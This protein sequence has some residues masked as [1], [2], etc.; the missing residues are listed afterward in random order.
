MPAILEPGSRIANSMLA[1]DFIDENK[2]GQAQRIKIVSSSTGPGSDSDS[3]S[4]ELPRAPGGRMMYMTMY[5]R[6]AKRGQTAFDRGG[7]Q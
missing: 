6:R 7:P 3:G 5:I 2:L 4:S 1:L